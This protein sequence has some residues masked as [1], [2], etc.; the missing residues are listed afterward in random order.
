MPEKKIGRYVVERT[1]GQ[2]SMGVVYLAFDPKLHRRSAIKLMNT[3]GEADE[4]LRNRFLNEARSAARLRHHNIV[5]IYDY[6]MDDDKQPFIAME[7]LEGE[8]LK[9]LLERRVFI[10]FVEK[11]SL[12]IKICEA[13]HYAHQHK[14]VHRD[15]KPGNIRITPDGDVRIVDFGLARLDSSEITKPGVIMGSPYYM[16]PEQVKGVR[17]LDGRSDLFSVGVLLYE[18]MTYT[19]PFEAETSMAVCHAIVSKPH[20]PVLK[21]LPA[22]P[23]E[24]VHIIDRVLAKEPTDRFADCGELAKALLLFLDRVSSESRDLGRKVEGL[25]SELDRC[26]RGSVEVPIPGFLDSSLFD[27]EE[28]TFRSAQTVQF[29]SESIERD[30]DY[31]VLLLRHAQ[32]L[33]RMDKINAKLQEMCRLLELLE[34]SGHLLEQNEFVACTPR[35]QEVLQLHPLSLKAR[36]MQEECLRRMELKRIE[37]ERRSRINELL[38]QARNAMDRGNLKLCVQTAT[39]VL[40]IER[41]NA[42]G[43]RLKNSANQLLEQRQRVEELLMRALRL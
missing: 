14:I 24:L 42:E 37:D 31:G 34:Q 15:V 22:C 41:D 20:T 27:L 40:Q 23:I 26:R 12:I 39:R 33:Y 35:L 3:G 18:L 2:G 1:L 8:D 19:R 29:P 28:P 11:V 9:A 16:S 5:V 32:L 4:E 25:R 6:D 21:V 36:R 30:K 13:L 38:N 10:P 17:E 43:I 7:Y